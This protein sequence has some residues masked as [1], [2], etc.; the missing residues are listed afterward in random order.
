[1]SAINPDHYRAVVLDGVTV[2][3]IDV[4]EAIGLDFSLGNALKYAW[5]LGLKHDLVAEDIGKCTWY[6][7]RWR[8][9][10]NSL[11]CEDS[12]AFQAG[13]WAHAN[14]WS[15]EANPY[16]DG[17]DLHAEWARGWSATDKAV[18]NQH[19]TLVRML[20]EMCRDF[21]GTGWPT[22]NMW[23]IHIIEKLG[24]GELVLEHIRVRQS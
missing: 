19:M 6:L 15:L 13:R 20:R 18:P 11:D 21:G 12:D 16:R 23:M 9:A 8:P 22:A 24:V 3:P 5:R 2:Q 1:M 10:T 14:M 17:T 7:D 4:I